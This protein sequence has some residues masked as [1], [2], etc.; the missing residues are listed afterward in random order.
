MRDAVIAIE[1]RHR[2]QD[3]AALPGAEE[4]RRGLR[5]GRQD[6]GNPLTRIDAV[7]AED[8]RRLV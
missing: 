4:D 5:R 6:D 7:L 1:H 2:Q 3:R 8:V